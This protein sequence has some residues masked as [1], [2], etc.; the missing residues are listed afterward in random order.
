MIRLRTYRYV[1][2]LMSRKRSFSAKSHRFDERLLDVIACPLSKERLI[3]DKE[4][5]MLKSKV[6]NVAFPIGA[7]G[8]PDLRPSSGIPYNDEEEVDEDCK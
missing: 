3:Y 7:D 5:N 2:V 8:I 6:L 4:N 1:R